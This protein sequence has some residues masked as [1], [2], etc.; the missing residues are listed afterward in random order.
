[1]FC[2]CWPRHKRRTQKPV[3]HAKYTRRK[4]TFISTSRERSRSSYAV[5]IPENERRPNELTAFVVNEFS[6]VMFVFGFFFVRIGASVG[7]AVP[8]PPKWFNE[9]WLNWECVDMYD[10]LL[11]WSEYVA[12]KLQTITH[13][14]P[15]SILAWAPNKLLAH[16]RAPT[17]HTYT[18]RVR[19]CHRFTRRSRW[20]IVIIIRR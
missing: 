20:I 5:Y 4:W 14:R 3:G 1:M 17:E 7:D 19:H 18:N 8:E 15:A 13:A 10:E 9:P 2:L 16:I 12:S 11:K 6:T